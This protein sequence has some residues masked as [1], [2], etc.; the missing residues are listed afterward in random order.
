MGVMKALRVKLEEA[1][2]CPQSEFARLAVTPEESRYIR[3]WRAKWRFGNAKRA[4]REALQGFP[5]NLQGSRET[6]VGNSNVFWFSWGWM[7]SPHPLFVHSYPE[8]C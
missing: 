3:N 2:L 6:P 8:L 5:G 4:G 1:G 7:V